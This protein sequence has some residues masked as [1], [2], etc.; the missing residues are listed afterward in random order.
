[1]S[2]IKVDY[3]SLG[4]GTSNG[5][6]TYIGTS[7]DT[8]NVNA[9][10]DMIYI[11][12]HRIASD[13]WVKLNNVNIDPNFSNGSSSERH[14]VWEIKDIKNGDVLTMDYSNAMAYYIDFT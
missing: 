9:D 2:I 1:M 5:I 11:Y 7:I 12:C 10:H 6:L 13:P 14:W 4:G 8:I 3:G